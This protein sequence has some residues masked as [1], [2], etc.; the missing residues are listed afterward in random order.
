M[1]ADSMSNNR[2]VLTPGIANE[3]L[4]P[5]PEGVKIKMIVET[6]QPWQE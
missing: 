3:I 5:D 4:R 6:G 1:D 2:F